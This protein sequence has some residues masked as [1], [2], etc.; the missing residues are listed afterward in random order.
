MDNTSPEAVRSTGRS[1]EDPRGRNLAIARQLVRARSVCRFAI[2]C[3]SSGR[4]RQG[5]LIRRLLAEVERTAENNEDDAHRHQS[6]HEHGDRRA[7]TMACL[8]DDGSVG[9]RA[10]LRIWHTRGAEPSRQTT[11][12]ARCSLG[13]ASI[14]QVGLLL[15]PV[16]PRS[17]LLCAKVQGALFSSDNVPWMFRY[18]R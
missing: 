10:V 4:R 9:H 2:V 16:G 7:W 3:R 1:L 13:G 15:F 17:Y 18:F 5:T 11:S 8:D 14:G 12:A 6:N